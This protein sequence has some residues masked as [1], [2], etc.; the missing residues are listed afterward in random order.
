MCMLF[1]C[2]SFDVID[3]QFVTNY[4]ICVKESNYLYPAVFY[5]LW[6]Q[7][8]KVFLFYYKF[9]R[10]WPREM[11]HNP[12]HC[13]R[14]K[15]LCFW[16]LLFNKISRLLSVNYADYARCK[17]VVKFSLFSWSMCWTNVFRMISD[18]LDMGIQCIVL[19]FMLLMSILTMC[20]E[21]LPRT[22]NM[23]IAQFSVKNWQLC[24]HL[25]ELFGCSFFEIFALHLYSYLC[26]LS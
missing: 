23:N 7:E 2:K 20:V 13:N 21:F 11:L 10:F 12:S 6:L 26:L 25:R 16:L 9:F 14:H 4:T 8:R 15:E 1:N 19:N 5:K 18:R 3:V 24:Q 22:Y 17:F